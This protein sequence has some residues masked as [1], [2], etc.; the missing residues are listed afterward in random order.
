VAERGRAEEEEEQEEE[1]EEE[2]EE[3][4]EGIGVSIPEIAG[5]VAKE[6]T[7]EEGEDSSKMASLK[8]FF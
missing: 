4:E 7:R 3:D 5:S 1:E 6:I 2:E 8:S